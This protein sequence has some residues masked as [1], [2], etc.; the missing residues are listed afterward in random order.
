MQD[1][2]AWN[3]SLVRTKFSE[4]KAGLV[5][6]SELSTQF[7]IRCSRQVLAHLLGPRTPVRKQLR[8]TVLGIRQTVSER[9]QMLRIRVQVQVMSYPT[10]EKR[11]SK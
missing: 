7:R 8:S 9:R 11:L 6:I 10:Q 3:D 4:S 1:P 5:W 2:G